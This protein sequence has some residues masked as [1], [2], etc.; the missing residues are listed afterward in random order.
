MSMGDALKDCDCELHI[1]RF[2]FM[3]CL[4]NKLQGRLFP[5]PLNWGA[6]PD[7]NGTESFGRPENTF[8][9]S[10]LKR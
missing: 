10:L 4:E 2:V 1:S 9:K 5:K 3:N 6:E 8:S 7:C